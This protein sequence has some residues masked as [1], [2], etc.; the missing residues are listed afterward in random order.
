MKKFGCTLIALLMVASGLTLTACQPEPDR[1]VET[2]VVTEIVER[3]GEEVEVTRVVEREVTVEPE[4]P[5]AESWED[6][7]AIKIGAPVILTGP[8]APIGADTV[9]GI[10]LAVAAINDEGGVLGKPLEVIYADTKMTSAEDATLAAETLNRA[11]VTAFFPGTAY[12]P[13]LVHAFGKY[14]Q[15]LWHTLAQ[16]AATDAYLESPEEYQNIFQLCETEPAYGINGYEIISNLPYEFPNNKVALLGGDITYDMLIQQTFKEEAVANG[17]EVV[18]DDTYAYGNTEF[19]AQLAKIRAEDP[20][21]I[22]GCITSVDSAVAFMNQFWQDPTDSLVYIQWAPNAPEFRELLGEKANGVLW[23]TLIA[24]LPTPEAEA[25]HDKF[26]ETQGREPGAT[27][28]YQM[29]DNLYMWKTAVEDCGSPVDYDCVV[30]WFENLD[31]H[32]YDGLMG[33]YGMDPETHNARSGDEWLPLHFIQIQ[34]QENHTLFL[35]TQ[36]QEGEEFITPS[37]IE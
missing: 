24:G 32:P 14:D 6:W 12:G 11:G 29:W 27:M 37:W 21:I 19:G 35:G 10:E 30:D 31:D 18:L 4:E 9:A 26:V 7:E 23:Q 33:T 3:E 8:G 13:A 34:D 22:W 36:Q 15:P 17:W 2:V 28:A 5:E 16:Q 25:F 20:A 1:I